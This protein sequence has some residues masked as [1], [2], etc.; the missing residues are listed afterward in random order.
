VDVDGVVLVEPGG[1]GIFPTSLNDGSGNPIT[2]T[3]GALNVNVTGITF[4]GALT[5]N[6]TEWAST[7][8]GNPTSYGTPPSGNVIGVNA[9]VSNFPSSQAV[10]LA[11]TTITGSVAVT[12]TF[13]QATQPVSGTVA[14]SN[15]PASQVVTLASTTITGSVAVTGTFWQATQ[16]VS[17]TVTAL[18]G[19]TPWVVTGTVG[20]TGQT[21]T[22]SGS[23]AT[24]GLNTYIENQPVVSSVY[25]S[26]ATVQTTGSSVAQQADYVGS[27]FVKP[28]RRSQTT[29]QGTTIAS[30]SGAT[31]ILPVGASGIFVDLASLTI[32]VT[33]LAAAAAPVAFT[34]TIGDGTNTYIYDLQADALGTTV[35]ISNPSGPL[36]LTFNPPIPGVTSAT[37]WKATLS[38][39]NVTVH[40]TAVGVLQGAS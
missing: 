5:N 34:A 26:T 25:N 32:S 20:V 27:L 9:S 16:P 7:T 6:I 18:Q 1:A 4:A 29:A 38:V 30:S 36:A 8:L 21:F 31:N 39:N 14:V 10:T 3:G 12:G 23:P 17:G 28:Y 35:L 22:V 2:S 24:S 40:I 19:T 15:F 37:Q 13:F 11:S 33:P